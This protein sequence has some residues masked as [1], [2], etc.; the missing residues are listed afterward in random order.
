MTTTAQPITCQACGQQI[1]TFDQWF[2]EPCP[3]E[4][5]G[6]PGHRLTWIKLMALRWRPVAAQEREAYHDAPNP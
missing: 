3:Q 2:C 5:P 4:I 6:A 1:T